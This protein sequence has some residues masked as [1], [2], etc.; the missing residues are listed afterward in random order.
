MYGSNL[1]SREKAREYLRV[2]HLYR[3]GDLP[4]ERPH[5]A[6][7]QLSC[8]AMADLPRAV[9]TLKVVDLRALSMLQ[10]HAA[11]ID[12][13]REKVV[14]TLQRGKRVF[15]CGCGATGRLSLSLEYLWRERHPNSEQVFAFMAGGDVA[16]VHSLEGFED[17]PE[18]GARHLEQMGF[19]DGDLLISATEGG[20]TPYVI[21]AT[22]QAARISSNRPFFLYCNRDS[23]LTPHVERFR[24]VRDN[25][26]IENVCLYVGPMALAGSTRMQASTV[27]QLAVGLALL[28][29][30][31]DAANWIERYRELVRETDFSFLQAFVEREAEIYLDG[32]HVSYRVQDFGIT[33]LT[34]TTERAPTFSLV[35]F[36]QLEPGGEDHSLCYVAL[37]RTGTAAEAWRALLNRAPRALDWPEIDARTRADYLA[38]FDFSLHA[39]GKRRRQLPQRN[40]H[41]LGIAGTQGGALGFR[42]QEHRH[43]VS[44][45][46]EETGTRELFRHLLLK[47]LLNIHSTLVMGRLGRYKG[48]L[49]TWVTPTNGKLVDRA[50]RYVGHLLTAAGEKRVRYDAIVRQLF[51]EMDAARPGE[52]V[53]LRTFRALARCNGRAANPLPLR[54][55]SVGGLRRPGDRV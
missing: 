28:G 20:E 53:V 51:V 42:L 21:G 46:L 50:A 16:L 45:H 7:R 31:R 36:D 32:D 40:H 29:A 26:R 52:P 27:L 30:G 22:E 14:E 33:V 3:L 35:P 4:T 19:S 11:R 6:T 15:L 2:A 12:G 47:Q 8:W 23:A 49:M 1:D 54:A 48:N 13:L 10:S 39:L 38:R 43:D 37:D 55:P 9:E 34:D 44:L 5:D 18:Y 24:R 41:E 25:P 17:Y